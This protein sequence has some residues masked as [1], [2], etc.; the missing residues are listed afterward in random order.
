M[1]SILPAQRETLWVSRAAIFRHSSV[2]ERLAVNE[3]VAGSSPAAG[4]KKRRVLMGSFFLVSE[5]GLIQRQ[6]DE[7]MR[8][9]WF[10]GVVKGSESLLSTHLLRKRQS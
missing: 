5:T 7:I 3:D 10:G 9:R 6:H 1:Y 2:V 8:S 4:A